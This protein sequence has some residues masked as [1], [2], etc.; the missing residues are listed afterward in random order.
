M[1]VDAHQQYV[2]M[3]ESYVHRAKQTIAILKSMAIGE[4]QHG[5]ILHHYVMEKQKDVDIAVP[6][7]AEAK[8]KFSALSC[9][10]FD[11]GFYSPANRQKLHDILDDVVL[12]KKGKLSK[13]EKQ[14]EYSEDFITARRKHAAVESAIN[15]LENH[16]LD[17]CRDHG[18]NGFK[19][20]VAL[21]V[22]ARNIQLI[23]AKI[24][25]K[26]LERQRRLE[27]IAA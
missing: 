7:A 6:M 20:Y 9:C 15:A 14:I 25:Q 26:S 18:I 10:S 21:A 3:V 17:R 16:G 13:A 1:I 27:R 4:D 5:F 23:G 2:D 8:H 19:R 24:R 22:L 12:P 11:K